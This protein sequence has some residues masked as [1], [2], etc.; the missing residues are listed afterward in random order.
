MRKQVPSP[1]VLGRWAKK[2]GPA[3]VAYS[4]KTGKLLA[5]AKEFGKLWD[6]V[7]EKPSF[8]KGEVVIGHVPSASAV[9]VY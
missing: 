7:E 1:E 8:Q 6:K 2:Y 9:S 4:K 3:F 5:Q